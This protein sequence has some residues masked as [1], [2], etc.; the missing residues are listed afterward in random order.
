MTN[1]N[2]FSSKV[3]EYTAGRPSYARQAIE[4]IFTHMPAE[5]AVG[6]DIGSG[7]GIFSA[8]FIKRGYPVYCVEPDIF[9]A[10]AAAEKFG[11]SNLFF[12]VRACAE[13]T[14]LPD[15]SISLITAASSFHWFDPYAFRA[16]CIRILKPGGRVFLI[17]NVRLY[18]SF[19]QAQH[20]LCSRYCPK[21]VSLTH[22][23]ETAL[24]KAPSF[25]RG[26][27]TVEK[28][29]FPISYTKD[30]FVFRSLSSSYAPER[31]AKEHAKYVKALFSL[32]EETFPGSHSITVRNET[33]VFSG[34]L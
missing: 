27:F 16:E 18:D 1:G 21:F 8:E 33:A 34:Y 13:N 12:P 29:D 15:E 22:G 11:S 24:E 2:I 10:K 3:S 19:T 20:V 31:G 7:T 4:N 23:M 25:F 32:L 17:T 9:M 26:G 14:G 5:N 28:Y 6:A 30:S